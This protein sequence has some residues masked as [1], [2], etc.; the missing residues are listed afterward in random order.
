[1]SNVGVFECLSLLGV[2]TF[3]FAL[4]IMVYFWRGGDDA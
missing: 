4:L 1:M 2:L 3:L